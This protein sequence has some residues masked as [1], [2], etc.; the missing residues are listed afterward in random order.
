[1]RS[2]AV[3]RCMNATDSIWP[4][5]AVEFAT[6]TLLPHRPI[7]APVPLLGV[8]RRPGRGPIGGLRRGRR[9]IA[10]SAVHRNS[11]A[12]KLLD[13][14][15]ERH[16]FAVA[17]RNRDAVGARAGSA[18]DPVHVGFRHVRQIEIHDVADAV[19]IDAA[20][21]NI[22]RNE[23]PDR[24]PCE[25][26]RAPVRVGFAICCRG[27]LRPR[28]RPGPGRAPLYRRHAWSA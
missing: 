22:G 24:R 9:S 21:C 15:Q 19:H 20:R 8:D 3:G 14:A 13:V 23:R 11:H 25:R 27:S 16:L 28:F 26:Q 6:A 17:Q 10:A 18:A 2:G 12:N 1:M 7:A 5:A 4:T